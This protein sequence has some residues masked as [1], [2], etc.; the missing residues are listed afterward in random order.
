[1]Q[2]TYLK[3]DKS[4]GLQEVADKELSLA[5]CRLT[6]GNPQWSGHEFD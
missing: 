5:T 4:S 2:V 1:M 3:F 6:N